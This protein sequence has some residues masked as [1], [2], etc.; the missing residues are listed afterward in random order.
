MLRSDSSKHFEPLPERWA[1][2]QAFA[3]FKNLRKP[4][5]DYEKSVISAK[6]MAHLTFITLILKKP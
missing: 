3:W 6:N 2:E 5:K 1:V 4:A